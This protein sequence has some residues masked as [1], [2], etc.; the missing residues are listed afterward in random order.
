MQFSLT[1]RTASGEVLPHQ[2]MALLAVDFDLSR[3]QWLPPI[4]SKLKKGGGLGTQ[5][6]LGLTKYI[7]LGFHESTLLRWPGPTE[8][9]RGT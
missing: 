3:R 1:N 8:L 9:Q 4:R 6:Y 7:H 2:P 5:S